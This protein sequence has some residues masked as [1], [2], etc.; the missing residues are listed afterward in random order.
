MLNAGGGLADPGSGGIIARTGPGVTAARTISAGTGFA[1]ANGDGING[2]PVLSLN[3]AVALTNANAQANKP[4][5]CN[6]TTGVL[7][8]ACSLNAA[9]ALNGYSTG[10]CLDITSHASADGV[11]QPTINVDGVGLKNIM[12]AD[13][14]T[15]PASGMIAAGRPFR[16]CYDGT[17]FR[18][19]QYT[20]EPFPAT[21]N[22]FV[23][24]INAAGVATKAQPSFSN[25]SGQAVIGQ[26]PTTAV[27]QKFFG[28][29]APG[30][31]ATNLPG[32]LYTDTTNH[33]EYVCNAPVGT[34]APACTSVTAAGWL[35]VDGNGLSAFGG[36]TGASPAFSATPTFSLADVSLKSPIIV[37]P[38]VMSANV[39]AVTFTNK[40]AGARFA[41]DWKQAAAGGPFTV[42]YG[43][44]VSGN[45]CDVFPVAG[46]VLRQWFVV[47]ADGSTITPDGCSVIS[48]GDGILTYGGTAT[49]CTFTVPSGKICVWL[50]AGD[51]AVKSKNSDGNIG[52]V[53]LSTTCT[54]QFVS[55]I[56]STGIPTCATVTLASAQ[57][58][59]QGTTTTVP[60]G[61]A[62]GNPSWGPVVSADMNITTTT[63]TGASTLTALNSGAVGTC[64]VIGLPQNSRSAAYT[65][66]LA[67]NGKMIYHPGT[68]TTA[69]TW[70]IDS[71]AN[72]AYPVG[73]CITFINDTSAGTI[74][75]AI[76]SD[77]LVL[78][79][80]GTTGSRTLAANGVATACK[81]TT[82]RW[83]INGT[84]LT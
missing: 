58:A 46:S 29:A 51:K 63:C 48:G 3:T 24:A 84:G 33:H 47:G 45:A 32:D 13:G 31:V 25:L 69:R 80:A 67:D 4:W 27:T 6:S 17:V 10:M 57:F 26:L 34:G 79:G 82:T 52:V 22:Q 44:S 81:M 11:T 73:S 8:L 74:T 71:N 2:N 62:S 42:T 40:T 83:M 30:S 39:T 18:L 21:P 66:V 9:A 38:A 59:N 77:T 1:I 55:G 43:A 16:A 68:D 19:A 53:P 23:T 35:Q 61:N 37:Q 14:A 49:A 64:T 56:P 78:A 76:T 5:Y 60:H 20:G 12:E 65:T 70:T 72:V 41:I 28:A 7:A 75:I 54:N 15:I 36:S 50:D